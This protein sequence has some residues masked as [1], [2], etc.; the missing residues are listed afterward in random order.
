MAI[1]DLGIGNASTRF[2]AVNVLGVNS[3]EHFAFLQECQQFVRITGRSSPGIIRCLMFATWRMWSFAAFDTLARSCGFW[4][5][6]FGICRVAAT[7]F[8]VVLLSIWIVQVLGKSV[9][10]NWI[11]FEKLDTKQ[12]LGTTQSQGFG[13]ECIVQSLVFGTKVGNSNA[14]G[15]SGTHQ[16]D[17]IFTSL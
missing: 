7:G 12:V 8:L 4:H 16:D 6:R 5:W 13:I 1:D 11:A 9:K 10:R 3:Q 2:Q 15:Y 14:C 17:N